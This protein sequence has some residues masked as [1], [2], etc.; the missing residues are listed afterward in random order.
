M[1]PAT[2]TGP[3]E[4][5]TANYVVTN[6]GGVGIGAITISD[7]RV[8]TVSCLATYLAAGA[9]MTCSGTVITTA[10]DVTRGH[11][12]GLGDRSRNAG[13]RHTGAGHGQRDGGIPAGHGQ[14]HDN[15]Q[16]EWPRRHLHLH[17]DIAGSRNL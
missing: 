12:D 17:L 3:G 9:S 7:T 5:L 10:A 14:S 13:C 4:T 6:T 1:A 16:Y 15:R 8:T 2:F 11:P